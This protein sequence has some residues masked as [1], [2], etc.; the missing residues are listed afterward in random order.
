MLGLIADDLTGAGDA[1]VQFARR[2]WR[3]L[4]ALHPTTLAVSF[5]SP[6]LPDSPDSF[7][8]AVTT[9]SRAL[10]N[11]V[12]E[13]L[14]ADALTALMNAGADRVFLKIDSTMRGSVP[15][16]VAGALGAWRTRHPDARALVCPAYPAM[17][18]TVQS[19]VLLVNGEP[20]ERTVFGRDPVSPVTT[21][22][23]AVLL[24]RSPHITVLDAST[25]TDLMAI[26]A[27]ITAAGPSAIAVG[28]GG[29]AAALAAKWCELEPVAPLTADDIIPK[30]VNT[31]ILVQV[32]SLNPVSRAQVARLKAA[33]PDV[34]VLLPP[35]D[36]RD[37]VAVAES[38]AREFR[39]HIEREEWDILGLIG[40]DGARATL[41]Q[42]GA[43][44]IRIVDSLVE[45]IPL[46]VVVGGE[47]DG[48]PVFTK[49]GGFGSEDALVRCVERMKSSREAA[50]GDGA[51]QAERPSGVRGPREKK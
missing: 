18:R 40:G 22:D 14:T 1:S 10:T 46:G 35:S 5:G 32:S 6:T 8:V 9:D 44:G 2:G 24:P 12:A 25:D 33:F 43:S 11:D 3:T 49:A 17:G 20:V 37:P 50:R 4:L 51:P 15:G 41:A 13:Q 29:L 38:L 23:M 31:R 21:S 36:R 27:S 26:A 45:G 19:N 7:V 48:T 34:V 28:S 42:L 39:V 16:Q 47:A 30:R